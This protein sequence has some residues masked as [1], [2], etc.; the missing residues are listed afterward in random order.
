MTIDL[1]ERF[2]P[3]AQ[4]LSCP[5]GWNLGGLQPGKPNRRP[6]TSVETAR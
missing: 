5:S 2:R 4:V 1:G 6:A 3:F